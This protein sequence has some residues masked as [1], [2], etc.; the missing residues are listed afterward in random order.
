VVASDLTLVECD[1]VLI[2]AHVSGRISEA[3]AAELRARLNEAAAAW[4]LLRLRA[5]VIER[6]RARFPGEP[7][8]TLDALHLASALMV[9]AA[10]GPLALLSLDQR[11]RAIGRELGF[12]VHPA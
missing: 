12:E 1:R 9:R 6:D 8:R 10:A 11:I 7:L 3:G 2:R 4:S 5:D